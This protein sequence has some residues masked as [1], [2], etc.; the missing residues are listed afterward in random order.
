SGHRFEEGLAEEALLGE[1]E[2]AR[3]A[4][5]PGVALVDPHVEER[6][7]TLGAWLEADLVDAAEDETGG[8][9]LRAPPGRADPRDLHAAAAAG[10]EVPPPDEQHAH[11]RAGEERQRDRADARV[12]YS[13]QRNFQGFRLRSRTISRMSA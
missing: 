4:Q 5:Q 11:D 9:E 7:R 12:R 6:H 2:L 10:P 13:F 1:E 8:A 3:R